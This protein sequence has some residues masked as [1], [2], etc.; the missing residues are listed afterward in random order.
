MHQNAQTR[1]FFAQ[2]DQVIDEGQHNEDNNDADLDN[3]TV[4]APS[5]QPL[6]TMMLIFR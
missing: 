6:R 2:E 1:M 4:N 3:Y 5:L